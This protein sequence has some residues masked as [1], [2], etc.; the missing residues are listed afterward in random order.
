[1]TD[2]EH[3]KYSLPDHPVTWEMVQCEDLQIDQK[4]QR[5]LNKARAEG[6]ADNIVPSAIGTFTVSR[7]KK[8]VHKGRITDG[9]EDYIVD[10]YHRWFACGIAGIKTV[11]AEVHHDLSLRDEASLFLIKNRESYKVQATDE[12]KIG[13]VG[14][15]QPFVDTDKVLVKH[16]LKVGKSSSLNVVASVVA[17]V[18]IVGKY[19]DSGNTLDRALTISEAA[20]GRDTAGNSW[21]GPLLEGISR[22]LNRWP[23]L[24]NVDAELP[25]KLLKAR[26]G[27]TAERFVTQTNARATGAGGPGGRASAAY[28]LVVLA[29]NSGRTGAANKVP[30]DW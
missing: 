4:V 26:H 21:N 15:V 30:Q 18:R 8:V 1:M 10:G 13:L 12:Y 19:D 16:N 29:W 22:F 14:G 11:M 25:K 7:R 17:V 5:T 24:K 23:D 2:E 6:I 28:Q 20:F 27:G 3:Q 9:Y